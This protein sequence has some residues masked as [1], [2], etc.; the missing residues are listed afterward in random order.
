LKTS[1]FDYHLPLELIAQSPAD[2]RD[3]SRLLV[4]NKQSGEVEHHHFYE[5]VDYL[6]KGDV[7]VFNDSRVIPARL[8]GKRCGTGGR[9]EILL[10][11]R[12]EVGL[13]EALV[14]PGKRLRP[15]SIVEI[16][17]DGLGLHKETLMVKIVEECG[18]GVKKVSLSDESLLYNVGEIPLPPYIHNETIDR[19]RYQTIYAKSEG[20]V[21]APT[22]GLHFT[23]ELL[24]RIKAQGVRCCFVTLHVGLDTFRP[25]KEEDPSNHIIHEEYAVLGSETA[26]ELALAKKEGRRIICVGTTAVRIVEH[27]AMH[28]NLPEV[29]PFEGWVNIFIL[30]GY[31][32]KLVDTMVTNFHLPKSSLLMLVS[33]FAGKDT[34]SGA[35]EEAIRENYRF[36]SFGDAMLIK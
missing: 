2:K 29:T 27:V 30:P 24:T 26:K 6:H 22:A 25:V 18:E 31:E 20:S 19:E 36:F 23:P 14:K 35:Y 5:L 10:L 17:R 11:K 32:F 21:A 12:L 16:E 7:L 15:N 34:I 4:L 13:W 1:D 3:Q 8:R 33:A 9:V 28:S